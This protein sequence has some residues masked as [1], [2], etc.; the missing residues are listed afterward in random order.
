MSLKADT[1]GADVVATEYKCEEPGKKKGGVLT[2]SEA[3]EW[4]GLYCGY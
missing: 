1:L 2:F 3:W 4:E